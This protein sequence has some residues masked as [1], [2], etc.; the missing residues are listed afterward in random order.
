[1][2]IV[3]LLLVLFSNLAYGQVNNPSTN[4]HGQLLGLGNDDHPQYLTQSRGDNRYYT[5]I[6]SDSL[7][8]GKANSTHT[9]NS[10]DLTPAGSDEEIQFNDNGSF[11]A[12]NDLTFDG[13]D[14]EV[15]GKVIPEKLEV[16]KPSQANAREEMA[17]FTISDVGSSKFVMGNLTNVN[18]QMLPGLI[19]YNDN[20]NRF[21][22][23]LLALTSDDTLGTTGIL[24]FNIA[25]IASGTADPLNA[26]RS[27]ISNGHLLTLRNNGTLRMLMRPNGDLGLGVSTVDEK[28]HVNGKIKA[29]DDIIAEA[30]VD[31]AG[32]L[33][34][35]GNSTIGSTPAFTQSRSLKVFDNGTN[36]AARVSLVA[37][38]GLS[39][40]PGL[41]MLLDGSLNKRTLIR[42]DAEA[43]NDY[44]FNF[45]TSNNNSVGSAMKLTGNKDLQV[46]GD[47]EAISSSKGII[48]KSPNGTRWRV[49]IDNSGN[50]T[51][52]S[53]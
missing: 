48:L 28:L 10:G 13:S 33:A 39:F 22:I 29:E 3:I 19:G 5:E 25:S 26:S 45:F 11:S 6:E 41:E 8:S 16:N 40:G 20:D 35:D 38:S 23:G 43:S 47:V 4:D 21:A 24:D 2:K 7:L 37:T 53:L 18:S 1:M 49:K 44:G 36:G 52:S 17:S 12:S 15:G 14:L 32:N 27:A 34:I 9:H 51:T 50:L 30:D 42:M 46:S 31:V